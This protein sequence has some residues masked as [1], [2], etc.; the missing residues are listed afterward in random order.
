MLIQHRY[1][2]QVV[3]LNCVWLNYVLG[4]INRLPTI[5]HYVDYFTKPSTMEVLAAGLNETCFTNTAMTY[6]NDGDTSL[7]CDVATIARSGFPEM[8]FRPEIQTSMSIYRAILSFPVLDKRGA[9]S[10]KLSRL[11]IQVLASIMTLKARHTAEK[12]WT[13]GRRENITSSSHVSK[14]DSS[15]T[16]SL[17]TSNGLHVY[18]VITDTDGYRCR[19]HWPLRAAPLYVFLP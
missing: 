4:A 14:H 9:Q 7:H 12:V 3:E 18:N 17:P 5:N 1:T 10:R 6:E 11:K 15:L 16:R 2:R 8:A 13:S 19:F